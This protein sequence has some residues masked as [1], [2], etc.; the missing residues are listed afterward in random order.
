MPALA[1]VQ[2]LHGGWQGQQDQMTSTCADEHSLQTRPSLTNHGD[3]RCFKSEV[4]EE[5]TIPPCIL[6]VFFGRSY[7]SQSRFSGT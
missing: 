5:N 3:V 6:Q 1:A 7:G 2:V 4:P